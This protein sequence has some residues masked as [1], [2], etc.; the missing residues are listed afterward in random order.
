LLTTSA[1]TRR[2]S[3]AR[4]GANSRWGNREAAEA[5]DRD[6]L[7]AK[8]KELVDTAP[9]LTEDQRRRLTAIIRGGAD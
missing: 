2:N 6:M 5:A 3:A 7:A 8:I 1:P 4:K 9:P